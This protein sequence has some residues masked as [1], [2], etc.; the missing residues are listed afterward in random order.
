MPPPLAAPLLPAEGDP[1][2]REAAFGGPPPPVLAPPPVPNWAAFGGPP[3]PVPSCAAL[4]GPPPPV[5]SCAALGGPPPPVPSCAA[6]GGPPPARLAAAD[7]P[8]DSG[9][10][11]G[12]V[13]PG[14]GPELGAGPLLGG[15]PELGAAAPVGEPEEGA[16]LE[17]A[18][19]TSVF[20]DPQPTNVE[21]TINAA[22]HERR[23]FMGQPQR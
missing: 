8:P 10:E 4:G 14:A 23:Y 3:P 16:A 18:E 17:S 7:P 21:P 15:G 11:L 19:A 2:P 6:L 5:P 9:S 12:D 13:D 22:I 20:F 1:K